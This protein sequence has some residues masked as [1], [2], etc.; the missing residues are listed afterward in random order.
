MD[1]D[2]FL[3]IDIG[4]VSIKTA[5]IDAHAGLLSETYTRIKGDPLSS[6]EQELASLSSRFSLEAVRTAGITGSGGKQAAGLINA[7][8]VNEI[9]AQA[10]FAGQFH[11]ETASIIEMGGEDAKLIML[12]RDGA[13]GM[14][15]IE[16]FSMN[17]VCAAGTGSF[18]DQQASRLHLT[19]EDFGRLA[20][21]STN[22]P[23]VAGR[24]SVFAKS[25]MIHLQ[26]IATPDYDIVAGLCFA[27]A[28]N[29]KATVGR[30]RKIITPALF[31]G[32]VAA[33]FGMRRALQ[34]VL[35][36]D[37]SEQ[38]GRASCRARV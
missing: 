4:S 23:R 21:R 19:I 24:C 33:N 34:E 35:R 7:V 2:L 11:P 26:Q 27:M 17:T 36:L 5:L 25:D 31:L 38:I 10:R 30:G 9:L 20:L 6:L 16:D 15:R 32:G 8:F 18:L 28:R 13:G 1:I 29:F 12:G 14:A 3:G 22:P 37:A